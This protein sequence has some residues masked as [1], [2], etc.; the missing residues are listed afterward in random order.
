MREVTEQDFDSIYEIY[1]DETVYP[2]MGFDIHSKE[3]FK[4]LFEQMRKRTYFWI[5]EDKNEPYG[6]CT[7]LEDIGRASHCAYLGAFGIK[8]SM[9]GKGLG[10][11]IIGKVEEFLKSKNYKTLFFFVEEDNERGMNFYNKLGFE[12]T[13]KIPQYMKRENEDFY[14]DVLIFTKILN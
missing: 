2:F 7:I 3:E 13:G 14:I 9:Q 4:P 8:S 10:R 11:K 1:M 6:M 5:F 12:Q